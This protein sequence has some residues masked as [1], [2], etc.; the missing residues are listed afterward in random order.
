MS[1]I[2]MASP[3]PSISFWAVYAHEFPKCP[4]VDELVCQIIGVNYPEGILTDKDGNRLAFIRNLKTLEWEMIRT[5][6][7]AVEDLS[8]FVAQEALPRD[9]S[10][11]DGK[12]INKQYESSIKEAAKIIYRALNDG[13]ASYGLIYLDRVMWECY[14]K[15]GGKRK[16]QPLGRPSRF[17][18]KF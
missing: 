11:E 9:I 10:Y 17:I 13:G 6:I 8:E 18:E 12:E 5:S 14:R 7:K 3:D 15:A 1:R 2:E 16:R 4:S